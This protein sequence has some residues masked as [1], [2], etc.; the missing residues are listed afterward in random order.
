MMGDS[1]VLKEEGNKYFKAGD[2]DKA[3]ACYTQALDLS[4]I[5][6]TEKNVIYKNRAAVHLK[7]G[8]F[9]LAVEDATKALEFAPNDP[10]A[11]FRRCQAYEGL[12]K[13]DEA[14]RDAA[15]LMKIDPSNK[16]ITPIFKRLNPIVQQKV[17]EQNS[18]TNKVSQ[19]FNLA[20]DNKCEDPDKRKQAIN[21]LIVLAREGASA[22][23]ICKYNGLERIKTS[24]LEERDLSLVVG[25]IRI[26]A[27]LSKESKERSREIIEKIGVNKI[28]TLMAMDSSEL[29]SS[30][31]TLLQNLMVYGSEFDLFTTKLEKYKEDKKKGERVGPY[32]YFIPDEYSQEYIDQIFYQLVKMLVNKKVS[33]HGRDSAMEIMIK[34][35]DR[36]NGIGWMKKFL[37]TEGIEGLL[38]VAG[39]LKVH[40][41]IPVT[42]HSRMHASVCLSKVWDDTMSDKEREIFKEKCSEYFK[43]LFTD[44][45]LESKV[46]AI[47]AISTLLQGPYEVGNMILGTEG[48]VQLMFALANSETALHQRIAVEAI[49]HSA[50]KKNRCTG[51]LKEAVPV[52][53]KLYQH[54]EDE[55]RVR[56]LVGLCKLGSFGG[57]DASAKPMADGSTLTLAKVCRNFLKNAA[58]DMR[59]WAA[60][61]MAYLSLDAEVKEE[62]IEDTPAIEAL[63]DLAKRIDK[64]SVYA[65]VTILVNLTNSYDKQDV[66][67]ELIEMAK[68]AKQHVPEDHPKDAQKYL[69]ARIHKL[70][71]CGLVNAL[72]A[73]AKTD[74]KNSRELLCRVYMALATEEKL[75]GLIVQQ[76]GAKSLLQLALENN[77]DVGKV[78]A[79]HALAKVA[80]TMDPQVAFPGQRMYEVVRP[81]IHLLHVERSSLQNF[82]ALLALTNLASVSDSVRNRI[83][84]E[85]GIVAIEQYMFE[86]HEKLKVAA[87]ECMC[88]MVMNEKVVKLYE[89]ENDKVKLMLLYCGE[90]DINLVKAAAGAVAILSPSEIVCKK[91]VEVAPWN[92]ILQ[93]LV[94]N[95]MAELQHR[96]CYI[97][98]NMMCA[99]KEIAE[100]IVESPLFEILMAVTKIDLPDRKKAKECCEEALNKAVEYG[101]VKPREED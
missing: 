15:L 92:E 40:N 2:Y 94:A 33:A 91:I 20:F 52:L 16:A 47:E 88:N 9:E 65:S 23:M 5:K 34:H 98:Y 75:R 42:E 86:D 46:E 95:E 30:C 87:T 57:T 89:K 59:K 67:P 24:L 29:A 101:L 55:T 49:V 62:L 99:N 100:K 72:V 22:T 43:D 66:M 68:F 56:A 1:T 17:K 25:G 41:T 8:G 70:A 14:F 18:M 81:M 73:L 36:L 97:V 64:N 69:S 48:V 28:M 85:D 6:D 13:V 71:E 58:D 3:L 44:E 45:I 10:K 21:N 79:A 60:E 76:G 12:D 53:K 84:T 7:K 35:I 93:T 51:I 74:S 54:G 37:F 63:F 11:L 90:E 27:C 38:T 96:G 31:C 83:V 39:T 32:P 50:S 26:L 78:L 19:M 4:N 61:G 77:T 82:E 80:V